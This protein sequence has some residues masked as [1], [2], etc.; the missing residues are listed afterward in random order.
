MPAELKQYCPYCNGK[1]AYPVNMAGTATNC[2]HCR[3]EVEL[4]KDVQQECRACGEKVS[5]SETLLGESVACPHC[6]KSMKLHRSVADAFKQASVGRDNSSFVQYFL[7]MGGKVEGP[8][9]EPEMC[10][11]IEQGNIRPD[12]MAQIGDDNEWFP[13]GQ[14]SQFTARFQKQN[15]PTIQE[16]APSNDGPAEIMLMV[17]GAQH[18]PYTIGQIMD[19]LKTGIVDSR[20][21]AKRPGLPGWIE[22]RQWSEFQDIARQIDSARQSAKDKNRIKNPGTIPTL[23]SGIILIMTIIVIPVASSL[24]GGVKGG[25]TGALAGGL[26]GALF[27]FVFLWLSYFGWAFNNAVKNADEFLNGPG[28]WVGAIF[29]SIVPSQSLY[30]WA[31]LVFVYYLMW[32]SGAIIF[33]LLFFPT[34]FFFALSIKSSLLFF[35]HESLLRHGG[36]SKKER[37]YCIIG[38]VLS[39]I[40]FVAF[41]FVLKA[42]L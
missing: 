12:T 4:A 11:L 14:L 21:P 3:R 37:T 6:G 20:T 17:M 41:A 18:G 19:G 8:L 40:S 29:M 9:T 15:T 30:A 33:A 31:I 38:M 35:S 16:E 27:S 24:F 22:L 42:I 5:F 34:F 25:L 32:I 7:H 39:F 1:I 26:G 13:V 2:P 36:K 28:G 10:G 23:A